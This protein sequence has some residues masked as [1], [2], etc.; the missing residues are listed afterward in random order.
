MLAAKTDTSVFKEGG[1]ADIKVI[2]DTVN[3]WVGLT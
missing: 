1:W 3:G 2:Q